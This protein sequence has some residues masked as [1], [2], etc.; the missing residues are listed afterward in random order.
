[1]F[2]NPLGQ[3]IPHAGHDFL[4]TQPLDLIKKLLYY[5]YIG[6]HNNPQ[7]YKAVCP[8]LPESTGLHIF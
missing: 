6:L 5:R 1:M 8:S 4:E 2:T 7:T 3:L